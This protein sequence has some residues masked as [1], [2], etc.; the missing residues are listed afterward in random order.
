MRV[1]VDPTQCDGYGKCN[2][3]LPDLFKLDEYGY[4]QMDEFIEVPAGLEDRVREAA[5]VCPTAA[6]LIEE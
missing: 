5:G 3:V 4:A 6:V 1:R 2:K